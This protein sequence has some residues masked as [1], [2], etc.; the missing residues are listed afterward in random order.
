MTNDVQESA[1]AVEIRP[2]PRQQ[3]TP[4]EGGGLE[5]ALALQGISLRRAFRLAKA[6]AG[7]SKEV[8]P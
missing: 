3:A 4:A 2:V 1:G 5:V 8:A 6:L 7:W